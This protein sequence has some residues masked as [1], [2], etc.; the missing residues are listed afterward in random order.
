MYLLFCDLLLIY[1][2]DDYSRFLQLHMS[3]PE[4]KHTLLS[5]ELL[6]SY[7]DVKQEKSFR[8]FYSI[9]SLY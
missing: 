2:E 9:K 1:S 3:I 8:L 7:K 6:V 5:D 4:L